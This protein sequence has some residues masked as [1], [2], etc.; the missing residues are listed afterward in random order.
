MKA[1]SH[2][3]ENERKPDPTR[4][5]LV[6]GIRLGPWQYLRFPKSLLGEESPFN[7][8]GRWRQ[9]LSSLVPSGTFESS[10]LN[11]LIDLHPAKFDRQLMLI[12]CLQNVIAA[13]TRGSVAEFGCF[14]GH[15]AI[16]LAETMQRLGD[17]SPFY[18][19][20]S[21]EGL[22]ESEVPEDQDWKTGELAADYE[23]VRERFDRFANVEVV[24]GFFSE[25]LPKLPEQGWKFAHVD[26]DL[27]VS[28]REV[29]EWLL[30]RVVPGGMVVYDDYGLE[31]CKGAKKAVDEALADRSDFIRLFLP[32]AQYLAI[33]QQ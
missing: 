33:R 23:E 11:D 25:T 27:F 8:Y 4:I 2:I 22:P 12:Q 20:D 30:D 3:V 21:F 29:N 10:G 15:T 16:H 26:A 31:T 5:E 6:P 18:L 32:T 17:V 14:R 1:K 19:L 7:H 24:K 9:L 13:G 28:I